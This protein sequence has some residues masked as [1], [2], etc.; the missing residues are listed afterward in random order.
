VVSRRLGR[1]A[2]VAYG[3][4][5][6]TV[7]G[8]KVFVLPSSSGANRR[9]DYEGRPDRLSWFVELAGVAGFATSE[10]AAGAE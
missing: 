6:W 9:R 7:A 4:Q 8:A 1:G 3:E 2:G 5:A 10:D